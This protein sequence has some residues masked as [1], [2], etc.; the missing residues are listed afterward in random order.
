MQYYFKIFLRRLGVKRYNYD[1]SS[2]FLD[3]VC[4]K[5]YYASENEYIDVVWKIY[6]NNK[7]QIS[8]TTSVSFELTDDWERY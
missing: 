4:G 3:F 1:S 5:T 7:N 8:P 2:K 6:L